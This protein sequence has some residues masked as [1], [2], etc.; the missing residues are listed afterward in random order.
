MEG[1]LAH[2]LLG[3]VYRALLGNS[4]LCT[5]EE[6]AAAHPPAL[7]LRMTAD[8]TAQRDR[9]GKCFPSSDGLCFLQSTRTNNLNYPFS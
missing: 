2:A 7:R 1:P 5:G 3:E 4:Q 6:A 8:S 9:G